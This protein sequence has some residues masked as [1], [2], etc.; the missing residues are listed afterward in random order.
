V[1]GFGAEQPPVSGAAET[2]G[3]G[4]G[5]LCSGDPAVRSRQRVGGEAPVGPSEAA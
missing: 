1:C 5:R 2:G 4:R 3:G